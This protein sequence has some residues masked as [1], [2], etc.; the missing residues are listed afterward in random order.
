MQAEWQR[1]VRGQY[2]PSWALHSPIELDADW[3]LVDLMHSIPAAQHSTQQRKQLKG[4]PEHV[5]RRDRSA[6]IEQAGQAG[7]ELLVQRQYASLP[8][9]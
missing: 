8:P 1:V 5:H 6:G 3:L 9:S 7:R 4:T 2:Y